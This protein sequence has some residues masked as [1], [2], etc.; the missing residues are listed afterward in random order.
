MCVST[1][2]CLTR[3]RSWP[4]RSTTQTT[5]RDERELSGRRARAVP[6]APASLIGSKRPW[7]G[8]PTPIA[9]ST[10]RRV[11]N[12]HRWSC[13]PHRERSLLRVFGYTALLT[14]PCAAAKIGQPASRSL[15]SRR[16]VVAGH[17]RRVRR[18]GVVDCVHGE[19][20]LA[21]AG[22]HP[23]PHL[24]GCGSC[25]VRIVDQPSASG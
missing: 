4:R 1:R 11:G 25:R 23:R 20:S 10:R 3:A 22:Q 19:R 12:R 17:A 6:E 24:G 8:C 9:V 15:R 21:A 2:R 14:S 16:P 5:S 7:C 18:P 13:S